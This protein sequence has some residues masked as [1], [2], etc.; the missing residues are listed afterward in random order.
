M[1]R[2]I[3]YEQHCHTPLCRHADGMPEALRQAWGA[4]RSLEVG[5]DEEIAR[6]LA[7]AVLRLAHDHLLAAPR[8]AQPGRS[9]QR[10]IVAW[11]D[12]ELHRAIDRRDA[13]DAFGIHPNHVT[14]VFREH[15]E[16]GFTATLIARRL[17]RAAAL[18]GGSELPVAEVGARCGYG[19]PAAFS[20]A[21]RKRFGTSPRGYRS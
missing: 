21:F 4:L 10:A 19:D 2:P 17:D 15:G 11:I 13:A 20:T 16:A 6:A 1:S 14:R 3:V 18:L 9:L 12:E 8:D 5:A 7:L